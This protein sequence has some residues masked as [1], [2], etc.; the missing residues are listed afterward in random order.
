MTRIDSL[1][2]TVLLLAAF[3][4]L[5]G[6]ASCSPEI[7]VLSDLHPVDGGGGA[8]A[9]DGQGAG[10]PRI[11]S[12]MD[13]LLAIDNSRGMADKQQLLAAVVPDLIN[14]LTNPLCLLP[15]GTALPANQQP[16]DPL[17]A[18]PHGSERAFHPVLDMHLGVVS[19]S[20]G[21][22]GGDVCVESQ[23]GANNNDMAELLTRGPNGN[24]APTYQNLGFLAWDP[25]HEL[26]PPGTADPAELTTTLASLVTG[27]GQVGCGL[28]S[29]LESWYRFLIEPDPY[30]TI[31][32]SNGLGTASG[33]DTVLLSQRKSFLRSDS[34]LLIV[35]LSDE[36]DCSIRDGGQYFYAAKSN[37]YHLPRAQVACATNPNDPCCKSCGQPSGDGCPPK[38]DECSV[39][40]DAASDPINLRCFDEKRRFGIEFLYP[41]DRYVTGLTAS[42]VTDRNGNIVPNPIYTDLNPDDGVT[43]L[44]DPSL[45]FIAGIVGVPWQAV[46]RRNGYGGP[47]LIGGLDA[48]GRPV[49]G[50][51]S[52][53]ELLANG[54]WSLILGD[55]ANYLPPTDPHMVEAIDPRPGLTAPPAG[56]LADPVNGH[57]HSAPVSRDDLQYACIV[58]LAEPLDCTSSSVSCDCKP[59][60]L[61][62][63]PLCQ[64]PDGTYSSTQYFDQAYPGLRQLELLKAV[65]AQGIVAPIC[66]AQIQNPTAVDFAYRPAMA[67]IVQAVAEHL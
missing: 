43:A 67:A 16:T 4:T 47:D 51:Q 15:D 13:V 23:A 21:D 27:A 12:R 7:V 8:G 5:L 55:P 10:P 35:V 57:E 46:A 30:E 28:E 20:L 6:S 58:P 42:S 41:I 25:T 50:L 14:G 31:E 11:A 1:G 56:Y 17:A 62:D 37:N 54:T 29:Q 52:A 38:G 65:G 60:D 19:S 64:A 34:L 66:P 45:V 3:A 44:R 36:N 26:V 48:N 49:G 61:P 18:C 63:T 53:A 2:T 22:H 24:T 59:G 39:P 9:G 33:T 40:N 32:A